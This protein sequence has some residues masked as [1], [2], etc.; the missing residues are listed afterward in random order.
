MTPLHRPYQPRISGPALAALSSLSP[1]DL[2]FI[3]KL[4]KA[5]LHAHLNG[6]VPIEVL[7]ELA[8][9]YQP[10]FPDPASSTD[11]T[12][13]SSDQIPPTKDEILLGLKTLASFSLD[14]IQE[15]FGAFRVIYALISTKEALQKATRGVLNSFLGSSSDTEFPLSGSDHGVGKPE[16]TYLELRT[17]PRPTRTL[18]ADDY[19][20]TVL[21]EV[22]RYPRERAA[23][24]VSVDRR[25]PIIQDVK[26]IRGT[27]DGRISVEEVIHLAIRLKNE[28]RR[29]VGIDLCGD[30]L[31]GDM[32]LLGPFIS[33]AKA[34]GLCVTFHIAETTHNSSRDTMTL[35][36]YNP[37]RLGHATFLDEEAK[38][39]VLEK[40]IPVEVCLSSNVICKTVPDLASHHIRYYLDRNH[41]IVVCTDD[42]LPF[43]T[44]LTA[45]YALL[46][47][48][49]PLGLG[50]SKEEVKKIAEYSLAEG[51]R[52]G[53][54]I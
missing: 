18:Y 42:T 14:N 43:R 15:F 5:E 33:K 39:F 20:R 16:C 54:G 44:S 38:D 50:L 24:I 1:S 40:N 11:P 30:P 41:P 9:T 48:P 10:S 7:Y 26:A 6:C 12:S 29:I 52:F 32:S 28:G 4:P 23:L 35:L 53:G 45:E 34:A 21:S 2:E 3:Q 47:T 46:L 19:L 25:M 31:A 27:S 22:E 17:T 49:S 13:V 36:G 8:E 37:D 51:V